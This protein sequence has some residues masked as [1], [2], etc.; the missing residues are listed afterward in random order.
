[1]PL[2]DEERK[3]LEELELDLAADDPGLAQKLSSGSLGARIRM[4]S[5][6]GAIFFLAGVALLMVGIASHVVIGV[7]GFLL[8]V[9]GTYLFVGSGYAVHIVRPR[10]LKPPPR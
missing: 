10:P 7:G 3:V 6:L 8:M 1:M 5:Y 4:S 2:S 9:T